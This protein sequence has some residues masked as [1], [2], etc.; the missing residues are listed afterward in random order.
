MSRIIRQ[1]RSFA[2]RLAMR[3]CGS[4]TALGFLFLCQLFLN[5]LHVSAQLPPLIPRKVLF[6]NPARMMPQISPDGTR[7]SYMAEGDKGVLHVFVQTIGRDDARQ[8]THN[9]QREVA[10]YHWAAD[11]QHILY[12]QDS[13]GDENY[14]IFSLDLKSGQIRDLTPFIGVKA[15]NLITSPRCPDEIL[16]GLNLRKPQTFDMYRINLKT[17]AVILD[18]T[19]PGDVLSWT[20][21][22]DFEIRAATAFDP[23]SLKT[24]VRIRD[25]K[26]SSWRPLVDFPFEESRIPGQVEGGTLI[27]G[28]SPSG[29]T[30][31]VVS[32]KNSDQTRLAEIDTSSGEQL[33]I[34][35][36][37]DCCDVA[38]DQ[39]DLFLI[40]MHPLIMFNTVRHIP[41]AVAFE[42]GKFSWQFVDPEVKHDFEIVENNAEGF[43]RLVSRDDADSKWLF[44]QI[45]DDGPQEFWLYDRVKKTKTF[46]FSDF[47]ELANYK[48][49]KQIPVEIKSRDGLTLV[50]YLTVPVGLERKNLPM[51]VY[52]HG[53]PWARDDWGY[54]PT[55]QFLANRGYAALQVNYRG[56]TGFGSAFL[57]AS[58][59]EWG[60]KTQ[61]DITDAV[62][63]AIKE[64]IADPRRIAILGGSGGGYA[65][66]RGVTTTPDLYVCA[67]DIVG[68]S[69]LKTLLGSMSTWRHASKAGWIRRVGD[70]EHDETLNRRLSPLYDADKVKVPV[71]I[72]Q[73]ANDPRVSEKNSA[74]M[75]AALRARN[76]PVTYVVYPDEGHGFNRPENSIDSIARIDV[77]LEKYLGGRAEPFDKV[78][79]SSAELR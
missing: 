62:L 42:Y 47:P 60:L 55:A 65:A 33:R 24:I 45:V 14:H 52:P 41:E 8:V 2:G 48:L 25:T 58:N 16:V 46:L 40:D 6:G 34:L 43:F 35:A 11:S 44:A 32:G 68:P 15:Q 23:V 7:L 4:F 71:L 22:P 63:W 30:L 49:A 27:A 37:Q 5:P 56:S 9:L 66:L 72:E 21:D 74:M 38:N 31:Y 28:F 70:V 78:I 64:G 51:V 13:A 76:I 26:E 19:N 79:G 29:R 57:N 75:V 3:T 39:F 10:L 59:H 36:Q 61:D 54:E 20:V 1:F 18:T 50:S 12:E 17:G 67:V 53:G 73:G 77:F 69:D